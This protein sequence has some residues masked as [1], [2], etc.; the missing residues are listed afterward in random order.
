MPHIDKMNAYANETC[1]GKTN[2]TLKACWE[3]W[4]DEAKVPLD[5]AMKETLYCDDPPLWLQFR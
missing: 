1:N 2:C 4:R 3:F 5:A